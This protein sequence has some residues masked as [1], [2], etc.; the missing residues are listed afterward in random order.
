ML[1]EVEEGREKEAHVLAGDC[2]NHIVRGGTK[3]LGDDGKLVDVVLAGEQRLA[4]EH[5][6]EDAAGAPD[7]DLDVVF[8]PGEHDLGG[9]VVPR[10]HVSRHLG[11]LQPREAE[12]ADLQVAV[13]VD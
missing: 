13:L 5:L 9:A 11:V 6:G 2:V 3:E 12:V 1:F 4:V 10:R 7:V 8:L